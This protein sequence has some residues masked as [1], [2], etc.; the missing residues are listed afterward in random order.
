MYANSLF[1]KIPQNKFGLIM[2][3][4]QSF[5]LFFNHDFLS[6]M[7]RRTYQQKGLKVFSLTYL[8]N[9]GYIQTD[10]MTRI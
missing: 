9:T 2:A 1:T 5:A 8:F 7:D 10:L 3:S 6:S 4:H